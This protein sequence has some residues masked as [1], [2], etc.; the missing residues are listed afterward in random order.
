MNAYKT[1]DYR[2]L[3]ED[4]RQLSEDYRQHSQIRVCRVVCLELLGETEKKQRI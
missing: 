4:Y 3:S 2:K 1:Q